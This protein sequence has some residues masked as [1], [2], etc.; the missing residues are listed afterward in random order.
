MKAQE[1]CSAMTSSLIAPLQSQLRQEAVIP[2]SCLRH[3]GD[4]WGVKENQI[5]FLFMLGYILS[6]K[7]VRIHCDCAHD[8]FS[9]LMKRD[10]SGTGITFLWMWTVTMIK[11]LS[12][13]HRWWVC[14]CQGC[15][16]WKLNK[17]RQSPFPNYWE[18]SCHQS[19]SSFLH[20]HVFFVQAHYLKRL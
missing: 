10:Y 20:L 8:S 11:L 4:D 14:W 19:M 16:G 13:K 17:G 12:W 18:S 7:D 15:F 6:P 5:F 1:H 9:E 2:I 3:P